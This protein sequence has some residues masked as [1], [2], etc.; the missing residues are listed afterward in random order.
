[1][2]SRHFGSGEG[3]GPGGASTAA[4]DQSVARATP[5]AG[6]QDSKTARQGKGFAVAAVLCGDSTGPHSASALL[7]Y[8]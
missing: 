2:R 3:A 7:P 5:A 1:M 8:P 4:V 6:L